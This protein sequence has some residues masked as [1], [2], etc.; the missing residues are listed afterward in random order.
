MHVVRCQDAH[1][2]LALDGH[3]VV[4]LDHKAIG[5]FVAQTEF[6]GVSVDCSSTVLI[7][8]NA[9]EV[10]PAWRCGVAV[11]VALFEECLHVGIE[12][13]TQIPAQHDVL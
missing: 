7:C 3:V 13:R 1:V 10:Q 12:V 4:A 5:I 8:S 9:F 11:C 2:F 6:D